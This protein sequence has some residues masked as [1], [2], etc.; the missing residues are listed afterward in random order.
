[1]PS[2]IAE[3][4]YSGQLDILKKFFCL[5][6]E[7]QFPVQNIAYLLWC[8]VIN[9]LTCSGTRQ[10]RYNPECMKF[11]WVGKK[12]FGGRFMRF[13]SGMKNET[14]IL[15][16]KNILDPKKARIN[17]ACP[18]EAILTNFK[19]LEGDL[20]TKYKPGILKPMI[21]LNGE[22]ED[23]NNS[24]VLMLDGKKIKRG[25]DVDL[26]GFENGRT[27]KDKIDER[28]QRLETL[29]DSIDSVTKFQAESNVLNE[30]PEYVKK[31]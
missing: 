1:L 7:R 25:T 18:S 9:F 21:K 26:L 22:K 13:M 29:Q 30:S 6:S 8:D 23:G 19:P 2:V 31:N 12:F 15:Q 24:Y 11:F 28:D 4:K 5:V 3:L 10:M 17:F 14:D 16:G 20:P 27:L